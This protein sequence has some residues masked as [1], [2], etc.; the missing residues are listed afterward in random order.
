MAYYYKDVDSL[1][2]INVHFRPTRCIS[3]Q[4]QLISRLADSNTMVQSM[5]EKKTVIQVVANCSK[6]PS[7]PTFQLVKLS[8]V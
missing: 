8:P 5:A 1:C 2:L 4:I 7:N 3:K 6:K